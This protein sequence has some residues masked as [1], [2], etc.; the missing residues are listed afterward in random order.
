MLQKFNQF[1]EDILLE[2]VLNESIIYFSTRMREHLSRMDNEIS[3]KLLDLEGKD[4]SNL[5]V[6]FIDSDVEGNVTFI[7]MSNAMKMIKAQYPGAK[8]A[9]LD[10]SGDKEV[11]DIIF[12][13][14][15]SELSAGREGHTGVYVKSRNT[16]R[17]GKLVNKIFKGTL[18]QSEVEDFVNDFKS[19]TISKREIIKLV[20]GDE[21]RYWYDSEHHYANRGTLASSCMSGKDK[22]FFNI[23]AQNPDTC[24]LLIMT[25]DNKL[26]ARGLVW[27][28]D[29]VKSIDGT[30]LHRKP[31]YLLDRV[32]SIEDYQIEKMRKFAK[33]R[34]FALRTTNTGFNV[35]SA[36]SIIIDKTIYKVNMVV[37]V[38][39]S[40]YG[41]TFPYMDTFRRYNHFDGTLHNDEDSEKGGHVLQS[42]DGRYRQSISR[43][44]MYMNQLSNRFRNF[45]NIEESKLVYSNMRNLKSFKQ[46]EDVTSVASPSGMGSVVASQ[47][48]SV[49]GALNGSS[50][51]GGGGISGSG[52][53]GVPLLGGSEQVKKKKK[54]GKKLT[55]D[56]KK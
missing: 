12:K 19:S 10:V 53:V 22:S 39:K 3:K 30:P 13:N 42:T 34:G 48:S 6:T 38:N 44:R 51:D 27:K 35:K 56:V 7:S 52:D 14:D 31:E 18:K 23:Y 49:P 1:S 4:I 24:Q 28:L 11:A 9:N 20:S 40:N 25:V 50:Y 46:F 54:I 55:K 21:I 36:Q 5:D 17:I 33:Y 26:V 15:M 45:L 41:N 2:S 43:G 29:S 32:Y 8:D 47:P 16:I 37:K